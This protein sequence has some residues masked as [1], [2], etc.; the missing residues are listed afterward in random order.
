MEAMRVLVETGSFVEAWGPHQLGFI[1]AA[2][3]KQAKAVGGNNAAILSLVPSR[4]LPAK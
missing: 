3:G 1:L 4:N 2:K